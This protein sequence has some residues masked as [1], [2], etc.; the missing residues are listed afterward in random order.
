MEKNL[1]GS[2]SARISVTMQRASPSSARM[3]AAS[4]VSMNAA[5]HRTRGIRSSISWSGRMTKHVTAQLC[6]VHAGQRKDRRQ[7]RRCS[8]ECPVCVRR[9]TASWNFWVQAIWHWN[10]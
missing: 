10:V 5:R 9:D 4:S 7:Q 6:G 2:G 8:R 3:S 1:Y